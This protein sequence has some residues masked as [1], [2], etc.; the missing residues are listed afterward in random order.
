M[1][2]NVHQL[3]LDQ[4]ALLHFHHEQEAL[5]QLRLVYFI[6]RLYLSQRHQNINPK[7][8][9]QWLVK[10][11]GDNPDFK[12]AVNNLH[13]LKFD[14][15]LLVKAEFIGQAIEVANAM[16]LRQG[17]P[18]PYPGIEAAKLACMRHSIEAANAE[19]LSQGHSQP[20]PEVEAVLQN[21]GLVLEA[22]QA[23]ELESPALST[24]ASAKSTADMGLQSG[25]RRCKP[26]QHLMDSIESGEECS[27]RVVSSTSR[28]VRWTVGK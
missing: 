22:E 3:T 18:Q 2:G 28:G 16:A 20:Y 13:L 25:M 26:S 24:P 7:V 1:L 11:Y 14:V 4:I 5:R 12:T 23:V 15:N 27:L 17:L 21:N 9:Q 8:I 6:Q 10:N 19:A